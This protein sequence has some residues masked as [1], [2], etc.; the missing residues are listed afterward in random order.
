MILFFGSYFLLAYIV[1]LT[2]AS[3]RSSQNARTNASLMMRRCLRLACSIWIDSSP[4]QLGSHEEACH[5]HL[6][7]NRANLVVFR[8]ILLCIL[9]C[10]SLRGCLAGC[11]SDP[12]AR[13]VATTRRYLAELPREGSVAAAVP[14]PPPSTEGREKLS[15]AHDGSGV[16]GC[17]R[18][19]GTFT[20][21]TNP[22]SRP[23]RVLETVHVG[24]RRLVQ[25]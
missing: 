23:E 17:P 9:L 3:S 2:P 5:K 16:Q 15:S 20:D 18:A 8:F 25:K 22:A 19:P 10:H 11:C 21:P 14:M 12:S 24:C 1:P 6:V 13:A 7:H 4:K